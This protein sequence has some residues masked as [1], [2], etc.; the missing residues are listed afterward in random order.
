MLLLPISLSVESRNTL[1]RS[2]PAVGLHIKQAAASALMIK[3]SVPGVACRLST[4]SMASLSI[5]LFDFLS[6]EV[7]RE[8]SPFMALPMA[9]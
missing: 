2:A 1:V 6:M 9:V 7:R 3:L 4:A 8:P 5:R